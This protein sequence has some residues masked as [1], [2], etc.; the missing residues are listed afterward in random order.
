MRSVLLISSGLLLAFL[1]GLSLGPGSTTAQAQDGVASKPRLVCRTFS[2]D[3]SA[4]PVI[5]TA[6]RTSEIGQWIGAR[7]DEGW[8]LYGVDFETAQKPTGYP[9]GWLQVCLYPSF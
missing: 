6:D 9:Q 2:Q 5:D 4:P 7:E 3:L 8:L 1:G